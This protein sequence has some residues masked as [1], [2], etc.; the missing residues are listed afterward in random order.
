M[1]LGGKPTPT[2]FPIN[3]LYTPMDNTLLHSI[4]PAVGS[5]PGMGVLMRSHQKG[6][7]SF[8]RLR[9]FIHAKKCLQ[10]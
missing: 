1:V 7:N 9:G 2:R 8:P 5:N 10:Q 4:S 3:S 6:R